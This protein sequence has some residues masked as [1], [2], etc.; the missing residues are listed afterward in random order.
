MI[1]KYSL[2]ELV[3]YRKKV[4]RVDS[5]IAADWTTI[6]PFV[7]SLKIFLPKSARSQEFQLLLIKESL[8][9][10]ATDKQIRA[11]KILYELD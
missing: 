5:I 9:Q 1:P 10:K 4:Y 6:Q 11:W 7:Y 3:V 8:L 2:E